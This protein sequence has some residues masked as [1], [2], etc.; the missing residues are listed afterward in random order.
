M[1]TRRGTYKPQNFKND[2]A[3]AKRSR[4]PPKDELTEEIDDTEMRIDQ[5]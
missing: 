3:P 4:E 5:L 2:K 1:K